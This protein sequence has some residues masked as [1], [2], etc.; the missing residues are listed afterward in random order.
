MCLP[1]SNVTAR[2]HKP[3]K[4]MS[5]LMS[6]NLGRLVR[7]ACKPL[8]LDFA[9]L[10]DKEAALSVRCQTPKSPLLQLLHGTLT[11]THLKCHRNPDISMP[12]HRALHI[13]TALGIW[14]LQSQTYCNEENI[15][16]CLL[17]RRDGVSEQF[18]KLLLESQQDLKS[19]IIF[20]QC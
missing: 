9:S 3:L 16:G 13:T 19:A 8:A 10:W 5:V 17:F 18:Q 20:Y 12:V 1:P 6:V 15:H 4:N 14:K 2:L 7:T 11:H